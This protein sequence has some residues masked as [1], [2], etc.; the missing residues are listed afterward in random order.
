MKRLCTLV[1]FLLLAASVHAQGTTVTNGKLV[2]AAQVPS[3]STL[4]LKTGSSLILESGVTL[5]GAQA[6]DATLTAIAGQTTAANKLTYWDGVD[7]ANTID[8]STLAQTFVGYTT[9]S[10]W[11]NAIFPATPAEGDLAWYNGTDWVRLA[12]GSTGYVLT[13]Q[14]DGTIAWGE[15]AGGDADSINFDNTD[16]GLTATDVQEAIDEIVTLFPTGTI[17]G[18]TDTQ[19]LTFKTLDAPIITT[20]LTFASSATPTTST[21]AKAAFDTNAWA[22]GRGAL[23]IHDGTANTYVVAALASDT[24]TDGQVP[25]W[26]TGGTIE[27]ET[28]SGGGGGGGTGL[29]VGRS[30]KT[31]TYTIVA[32][33]EG[34]LIDCT[35]G[36]FTVTL[37]TPATVGDGFFVGIMNSGSGTITI[38]TGGAFNIKGP[39]GTVGSIGIGQ[40]QCYVLFSNGTGYLVTSTAGVTGPV[41]ATAG[42]LATYSSNGGSID[43]ASTLSS[44]GDTLTASSALALVS[45][46]GDLT[47]T[48]SGTNAVR[49]PT[50]YR[51]TAGGSAVS[52]RVSGMLY[53]V[54]TP[55]GNV[56]TGEDTLIS[57]TTHSTVFNA[58]GMRFRLRASFTLAANGNNKRIRA[59]YGST[60]YYDSGAV[61]A[62]GGV[63]VIDAV[64][65]RTGASTQNISA[66]IISSNPTF[67]STAVVT[68]AAETSTSGNNILFTGEATTDDDISQKEMFIEFLPAP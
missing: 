68:T 27:W 33:D 59:K 24:P 5:S 35:S 10:Q 31:T 26:K 42:V 46:S 3:G 38:G 54:T 49:T 8:F 32:G 11:R 43:T 65:T 58:N 52:A 57:T 4:T 45:T 13:A 39:R 1:V 41:S 67:P 47:L 63:V 16:S 14:P 44:S 51:F 53:S 30:A 12:V 55:V 9:A 20:D 36:T 23:Q 21:V 48:P 7:D 18:T 28:P 61:A 19:T 25:T 22:T 66:T 34:Y 37:A 50:T 40:G 56:G 2:G 29:F 17:V 15:P 6:T 64:I 62:N 60:T